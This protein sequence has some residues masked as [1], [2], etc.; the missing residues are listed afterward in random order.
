MVISRS[1]RMSEITGLKNGDKSRM[2]PTYP[3]SRIRIR[4]AVCQHSTDL[5]V[6]PR[7]SKHQGCL[8]FLITAIAGE[9]ARSQD[10]SMVMSRSFHKLTLRSVALGSAPRSASTAQTSWWPSAAAYIKADIPA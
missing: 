5:L 1:L 3:V 10:S 6:A 9:R 2:S 8:S 7:S 4:P